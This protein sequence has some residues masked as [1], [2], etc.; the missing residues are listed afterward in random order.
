M[1]VEFART[2]GRMDDVRIVGVK[3]QQIKEVPE[4]VRHF[5]FR[6]LNACDAS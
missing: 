6:P 3:L 5:G 1:T 2:T 4:H